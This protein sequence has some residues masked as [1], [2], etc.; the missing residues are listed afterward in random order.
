MSI[1]W[2]D[3]KWPPSS[4]PIL[5]ALSKFTKSPGT[6][7]PIVVN[8]RVSGITSNETLEE[9]N[10]TTVRQTPSIDTEAPICNSSVV[11]S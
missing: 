5:S 8:V 1:M 10:S 4:S 2:P 7:F 3:S 11:T 6:L 9:L